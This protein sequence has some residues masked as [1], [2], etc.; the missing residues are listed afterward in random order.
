MVKL[1]D[2][3]RFSC[4]SSK[5]SFCATFATT[6]YP[7]FFFRLQKYPGYEIAFTRFTKGRF[8]VSKKIVPLRLELFMDY[9]GEFPSTNG[10][11]RL[12]M[13][14]LGKHSPEVI[15]MLTCG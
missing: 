12:F 9:K 2:R 4:R 14:N 3:K 8:T 6:S 11:I 15:I 13:A 7:G 5:I 1:L 10:L